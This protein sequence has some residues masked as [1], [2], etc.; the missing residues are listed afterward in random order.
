MARPAAAHTPGGINPARAPSPQPV[1]GAAGRA[2]AAAHHDGRARSTDGERQLS[3]AFPAPGG[4]AVLVASWG[5]RLVTADA[6][7]LM[8]DAAH[9][10]RLALEREAAAAAHEEEGTL[11]PSHAIQ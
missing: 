5:N 11:G 6:V 8:E 10:L 2:R 9:S 3:V 1:A 7:A 4:P